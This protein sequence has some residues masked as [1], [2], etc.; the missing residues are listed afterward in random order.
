MLRTVGDS[1]LALVAVKHVAD[2]AAAGSVGFDLDFAVHGI[3]GRLGFR[4]GGL[5]FAAIRAAVC[6]ARFVRAKFKFLRTNDA[7]FDRECHSGFYVS[8]Q[9]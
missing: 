8:E 4:F 6:E 2:G 5:G 7:G 9:G 3:C 1:A